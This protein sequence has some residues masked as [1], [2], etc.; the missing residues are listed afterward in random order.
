MAQT[1]PISDG[2]DQPMQHAAPSKGTLTQLV[3]SIIAVV[4]VL[5]AIMSAFMGQWPAFLLA[6]IF[7]G[8]WFVGWALHAG[9]G[10]FMNSVK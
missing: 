10:A 5:V 4:L 8:G 6:I 2:V 7:G 1:E 3:V 9:L